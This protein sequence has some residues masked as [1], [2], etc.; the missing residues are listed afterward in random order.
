MAVILAN[1]RGLLDHLR[2]DATGSWS[3][4]RCQGIDFN[5]WPAR[6][7][8]EIKE[9]CVLVLRSRF[10]VLLRSRSSSLLTMVQV[11]DVSVHLLV[12]LVLLETHWASAFFCLQDNEKNCHDDDDVWLSLR[13]NLLQL[14]LPLSVIQLA[15]VRLICIIHA[16]S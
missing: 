12:Q 3:W 1:G 15:R 2:V 7:R 8:S 13:F 11:P 5:E 16:K 14:Q 10:L 4:Q 6:R 9:L